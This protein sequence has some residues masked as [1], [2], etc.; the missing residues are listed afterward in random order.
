MAAAKPSDAQTDS[1]DTQLRSSASAPSGP[2]VWPSC[3]TPGM[4]TSSRSSMP[5]VGPGLP[6]KLTGVLG[7]KGE[8]F[9]VIRMGACAVGGGV[10][11]EAMESAE[12]SNSTTASPAI[13]TGAFT[14]VLACEASS[15][16]ADMG[17]TLVA[18]G[19]S[20]CGDASPPVSAAWDTELAG[21]CASL[22]AAA[23]TLEALEFV[24]GGSGSN[25]WCLQ[26]CSGL[27]MTW[28]WIDVTVFV[29]KNRRTTLWLARAFSSQMLA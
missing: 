15:S 26:G 22:S 13:I 7:W 20:N 12:A 11:I 21:C 6:L 23:L 16:A 8:L 29:F 5:P 18:C 17:R 19:P 24:R 9:C 27:R 25:S 10:G 4:A 14:A 2:A 1:S 28:L 3:G